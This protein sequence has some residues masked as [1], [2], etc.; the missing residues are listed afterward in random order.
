MKTSRFFQILIF[1][2]FGLISQA[3]QNISIN[4][5]KDSIIVGEHIQLKIK[6][7]KKNNKQ[8]IFPAFKDTINSNIE[9]IAEKKEQET[10]ENGIKFLEKTYLITSF[11]T[12]IV[13]I[14]PIIIKIVSNGDT[15]NFETNEAIIKV[16]PFVLIDTIPRD[17]IY[18]NRAGYVVFGKNGFKKEIEQ[19]I[20]DSLK[21]SL[22][23]DSLQKISEKIKEQLVNIFSSQLTQN[24]SIINQNDILKI[25]EASDLKMFIV[26]REGILEEHTVPGSVDTV[27]VKEFDKVI[28][29]QAL[30]TV[31]RIKDIEENL[32]NTPFTF[33]EFIYYLKKFLKQ[34]WWL[35][36]LLILAI[37]GIT[38]LIKKQ[39]GKIKTQIFRIKPE[40]PAHVI[41][42]RKLEEIR[43]EKLWSKGQIK[44]YHTMLSDTIREYIDKRF[45]IN[46]PEMTTTETLETLEN[47]QSLS[48]DNIQILKQILE[49]ADAVKFAK[50]QALQHE[51][52][53]ALDNAFNFVNNTKEIE[54]ISEKIKKLDAEIEVEIN[55]NEELKDKKEN[56]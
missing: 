54:E 27:F 1:L 52:N 32:F 38:Y 11:D 13:K 26:D 49:L 20:P 22:P 24:T 51:N 8:I 55:E 16:K 6:V 45:G 44:E 47:I 34:Y 3:Q 41:A 19:Y 4:L 10:D 18:A 28:Q 53:L 30:F 17:T 21:Q 35:I 14:N 48:S 43:K 39:S 9:I 12:G 15:N 5:D 46:S 7:P 33:K 31:F 42:L 29:N 2:L 25:V 36:L 40:E 56:E 50:Y 23:A 37:V